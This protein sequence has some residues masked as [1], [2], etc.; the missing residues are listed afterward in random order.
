MK[1]KASIA[2][3]L[4]LF[5]LSPLIAEFLL[6]NL[7][8]KMILLLLPLG[9]M[10]GAGAILVREL[11]R[12]MRQGWLSMLL[13]A[14]AFGV[15][16]EGLVTQSLFNP[17]YLH[18]RLL[19]YGF[20]PS[21]GMGLPWAIYVIS[22]HV[23]W[24]ICAPIGLTEC[25]FPQTLTTPWLKR[26][27]LIVVLVL[28]TL[29]CLLIAKTSQRMDPFMASHVQLLAATITAIV[30]VVLALYQSSTRAENRSRISALGLFSVALIA[31]SALMFIQLNAQRWQW[32][33]QYAVLIVIAI[34][35]CVITFLHKVA[36]GMWSPAEYWAWMAG[37]VGVYVW[38]GFVLECMTRGT[39]Q[40]LGHTIIA[41]LVIVLVVIA[42]RRVQNLQVA[43]ITNNS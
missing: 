32:T 21:L 38:F 37:G 43:Q 23:A 31:G 14:F 42:Y 9:L 17:N 13:L 33:W 39:E 40:L 10:Y 30:A 2:P 41:V 25:L 29:G 5:F 28:Y 1:T 24:S 36:N 11:V 22:I 27:S 8:P 15:I 26:G 19:D 12:H 3:T 16:E 18:L 4:V 7:A 35:I 6:G 20:I 34:E